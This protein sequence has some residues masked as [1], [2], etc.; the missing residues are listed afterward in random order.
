MKLKGD[1]AITIFALI[2]GQFHTF[3]DSEQGAGPT[4]AQ[5]SGLFDACGRPG[6]STPDGRKSN[7]QYVNAGGVTASDIEESIRIWSPKLYLREDNQTCI[8]AALSGKN[9]IM[10]ELERTFG[11]FLAWVTGRLSSGE[12]VVTYTRTHDMA[13]D[14]YTKGF[15][16]REFVER[17]LVMINVYFPK[18]LA[19]RRLRSPPPTA[20][21]SDA[22]KEPGWRSDEVNSQFQILT[23]AKSTKADDNEKAIVKKKPKGKMGGVV[24]VVGY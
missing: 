3:G 14:I 12:Y 8:S 6:Y 24:A 2:L 20:D 4:I 19:D 23:G 7:G 1:P 13:A 11:I 22:T 21:K 15:D 18:D 10:K 16:N 5:E 17:L 9:L